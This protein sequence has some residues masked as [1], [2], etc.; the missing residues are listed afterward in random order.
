VNVSLPDAPSFGVS[1]KPPFELRLNVPVDGPGTS[2]AV[3]SA[4]SS[5]A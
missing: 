4:V 1:V 2:C 3:S 5:P